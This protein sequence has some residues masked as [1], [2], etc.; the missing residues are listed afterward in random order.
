MTQ[1]VSWKKYQRAL[2]I[3]PSRYLGV[4]RSI[5]EDGVIDALLWRNVSAAPTAEMLAPITAWLGMEKAVHNEL[6]NVCLASLAFPTL[7]P[8]GKGDP[9][10][11]FARGRFNQRTAS[12]TSSISTPAVNIS[13]RTPGSLT[14]GRAC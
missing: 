5:L 11:P 14:G 2:R 8:R 12:G 4:T 7:F 3:N 9:T 10:D 1:D 6:K 13:L